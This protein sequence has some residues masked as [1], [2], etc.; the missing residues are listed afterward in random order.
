MF[1]DELIELGLSKNEAKLYL[2][3]LR[4]GQTSTGPLIKSSGLYRVIVYDSLQGLLEKGLASYSVKKSIKQFKA[5]P[6]Q[7]LLELVKNRELVAKRLVKKLESLRTEKPLEEGAFAYEGW[8]GIKAA[9]ENY[10]AEM[11]KKDKEEYLMVGASQALHE[12]LDAYFN[13][14][15]ER[16]SKLHVKAKLLFNE[17]NKEFGELKKKFKPVEVRYMPK[18]IVTPSWISTFKD[19]VL[20]GNS[21]G[22][23]MAF[24]I[25]NKAISESYKAYFYFMW[26]QSKP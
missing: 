9:Q 21:I 17:N 10:F 19:C 24:F 11:L 6:P 25:K 26:Q 3:L 20:I 15:H 1:D 12:R 16:R 2:A 13:Y 7:Q 4:L 23:P 5:E 18:K 22:T 8:K 14:F